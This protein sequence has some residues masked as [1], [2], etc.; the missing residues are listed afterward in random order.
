MMC[1][2]TQLLS[3]TSY[4]ILENAPIVRVFADRLLNVFPALLSRVRLVIN[5]FSKSKHQ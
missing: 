1:R 3:E 5:D 2:S 4:F